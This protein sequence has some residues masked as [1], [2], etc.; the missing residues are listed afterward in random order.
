MGSQS[1]NIE[2]L[3]PN[4]YYNQPISQRKID[5]LIESL[6]A[7]GFKIP[8]VVEKHPSKHG[9]YLI[10]DGTIRFKVAK[11][12]GLKQVPCQIIEGK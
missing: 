6:Q 11:Q 3:H 12:L 5:K 1:I 10:V 9:H 2:L 8:I 4:I 7:I